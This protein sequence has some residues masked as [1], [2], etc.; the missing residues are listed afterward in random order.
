MPLGR[1]LKL[2]T[3]L[4]VVG[5][6]TSLVGAGLARGRLVSKGRP[7]D[8]EIDLVAIFEPLEFTSTAPA[9]GRVSVLAW[10][11]GGTVDLR[12][13]G[14]DPTGATLTLRAIYGGIRLVV[15]ETWRV[16]REVIG[17]FG[18]VGDARDQTRVA[19][20]GPNLRVGGFAIFGGAGILSEAPDLDPVAATA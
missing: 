3:G 9:L 8:D 4:W 11:G 6:V 12:G 1:L 14:L 17:I 10:Y 18:G 19:P 16:E 5:F 13:A 20:D 7:G 15:P 2:I